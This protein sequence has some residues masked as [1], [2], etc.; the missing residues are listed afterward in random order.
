MIWHNTHGPYSTVLAVLAITWVSVFPTL[1]HIS[2]ISYSS[3]DP[4]WLK[5]LSTY[6][7]NV[8]SYGRA[9]THLLKANSN[10]YSRSNSTCLLSTHYTSG[11]WDI[12]MS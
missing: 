10:A 9:M 12:K 8:H 5:F 6:R 1:P 2:V 4:P 7:V 11:M 3:L